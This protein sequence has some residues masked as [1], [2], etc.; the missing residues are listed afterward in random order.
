[1]A[2]FFLLL[3]LKPLYG[4]ILTSLYE[5]V[6]YRTLVLLL[7]YQYIPVGAPAGANPSSFSF[8]S[9]KVERDTKETKAQHRKKEKKKDV[10]RSRC[11]YNSICTWILI[12]VIKKQE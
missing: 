2:F 7:L 10:G 1:M 8:F 4:F 9:K 6:Q 12:Q 3:L 11:W 5:D